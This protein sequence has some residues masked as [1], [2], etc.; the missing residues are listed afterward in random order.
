M[1][2]HGYF[3]S[4]GILVAFVGALLACLLVLLLM[5]ATA[6]APAG[7]SAAPAQPASEEP[8]AAPEMQ[9]ESTG[10]PVVVEQTLETLDAHAFAVGEVV[11]DEEIQRAGG[12][13]AFFYA[14]PVSDEVFARMAGRSFGP[15]CTIAREELR[16]VR[17]LHVDAS[18]GTLVGELVVHRNVAADIIDIFEQLYEASYPVH[19]MHLV[20]DYDADDDASC[21]D[22]NTSCFNY[23]VVAGTS[24]LSNHAY[25]LAIDISPFE[26]P[27]CI[28]SEGFVAPA[29][30][31]R[32]AD[33]SLDEPYMIH[34]GDLC[35]QLFVDHGWEWGGDWDSPKD[36]QHFEKPNALWE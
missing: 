5:S 21:A 4:P 14:E 34:R 10:E 20:D 27:Y 1:E 6:K 22:D 33:R 23:R 35:Y 12:R 2:R 24:T 8:P 25:G 31:G 16:Y 3:R 32:Y 17:V 36:Y 11:S 28:P 29:A 18:G 7:G 15:D 9:V 19:K 26:N 30:A 13:E